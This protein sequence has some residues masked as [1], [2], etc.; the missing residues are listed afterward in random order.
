MN[1]IIKTL[2]L[3]RSLALACV[4]DVSIQKPILSNL[5]KNGVQAVSFL[6][7]KFSQT[8]VHYAAA[9]KQSH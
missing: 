8:A 7:Y 6:V 5:P 2:G 3:L 4:G 1:H 9:N